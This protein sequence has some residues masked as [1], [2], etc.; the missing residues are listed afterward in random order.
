MADAHK[1][2]REYVQGKAPDEFS[3]AQV[4]QGFV[5]PVAVIFYRKHH[6][7]VIQVFDSVVADR[8]FMGIATQVFHYLR[9]P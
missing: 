1:P 4:H 5:S 3:I 9:W 8:N 6:A 7:A 2:L